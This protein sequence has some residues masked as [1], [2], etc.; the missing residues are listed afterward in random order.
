MARRVDRLELEVSPAVAL[1]ACRRALAELGWSSDLSDGPVR[2]SGREDD[3]KLCC[4]QSPAS[5]ELE[6]RA[7]ADGGTAIRMTGSVPGFG[8]ASSGQLRTRMEA[9]WRHLL[10]AAR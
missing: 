4:R 1:D 7:N 6:L 5:V 8:P 2:I 10:A 3:T 9:L